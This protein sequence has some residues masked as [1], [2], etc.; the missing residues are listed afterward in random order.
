[1]DA[2]SGVAVVEM[3]GTGTGNAMGATVWRRLPDLVAE[4]EDDERVR[5]VV[6]RG[7]GD[8]FTVGLDLRWYL[9]HYRRLTRH[10][11]GHPD[12][13]ARLLAEAAAMQRALD[14]VAAS[15]LPFVAAVHGGC[16]GAGL[17]LV[18][19][20]DIRFA[21]ADAF[22]SLR[23]VTI[24]VVA[25]LG[26]LQRL[27]R[28]IGAAPTREMALTGRDVPAAEAARLGL[29]SRVLDTPEDLFSHARDVAT[30]IARHS[31]RV[32]AGIKEVLAQ[33]Q[34]L[35]LAAG[36]RYTAVWNAAFLPAPDL[37]DRLADALRAPV[38]DGTSTGATSLLAEPTAPSR[39]QVNGSG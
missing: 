7:A 10:G 19:A 14:A 30:G 18:A 34:D 4:L 5:A 16:V 27:P 26:S 23:E 35:P 1:M 38:T 24:G 13:R 31:A 6:L 33:T 22:F 28:L 29:V 8:R 39:R 20:C 15:R 11:T 25:D 3:G 21:S 12:V 32:V 37:P 9:T 2:R 17:D 36:L